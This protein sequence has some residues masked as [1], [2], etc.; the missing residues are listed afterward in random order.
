MSRGH[1]TKSVCPLILSLS[2]QL[3]T[4][5]EV[6]CFCVAVWSPV[7]CCCSGTSQCTSSCLSRYIPERSN[8]QEVQDGPYSLN[9]T[10]T[11]LPDG[12]ESLEMFFF[13]SFTVVA[14]WLPAAQPRET[15]WDGGGA[16]A[17]V[18]A[19]VYRRLPGLQPQHASPC[20]IHQPQ[21]QHILVHE[22]WS[23]YVPRIGY[24]QF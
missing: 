14:L 17:G 21:Q 12:I 13:S 19:G 24:V 4:R 22:H 23:R 1:K 6:A 9:N 5:S 15:L 20:R 18:S 3:K 7:W 10:P 16:W 8:W 2:L 11:R